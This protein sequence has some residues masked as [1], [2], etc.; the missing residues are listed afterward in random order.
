MLVSPLEDPVSMT[1]P[2]RR[3]PRLMGSPAVLAFPNGG[4]R[5]ARRNA[6][7]GMS[8]DAAHRR[9]RVEADEAVQASIARAQPALRD[10]TGW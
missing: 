8:E 7:A 4:Q 5:A 10:A 2:L 3:T 9:A 1:T 6:W